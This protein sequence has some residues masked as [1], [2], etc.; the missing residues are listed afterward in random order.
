MKITKVKEA[1]ITV[2]DVR[3]LFTLI[4]NY[5]ELPTLFKKQM[6]KANRVEC[7][8][9]KEIFGYKGR[10]RVWVIGGDWID[11]MT[12]FEITSFGINFRL[13]AIEKCFR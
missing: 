10:K 9:S 7:S 13:W 11:N 12:K 3:K 8:G 4:E 5:H 1:E 6:K 2:I